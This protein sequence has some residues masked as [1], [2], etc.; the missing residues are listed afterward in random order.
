MK[1]DWKRSIFKKWLKITIL[2]K[3]FLRRSVLSQSTFVKKGR[4]DGS[5]RGGHEAD[6]LNLELKNNQK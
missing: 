1:A 2:I 3:I 5:G 4:K 6:I